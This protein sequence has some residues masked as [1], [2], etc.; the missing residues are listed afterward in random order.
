M[1]ASLLLTGFLAALVVFSGCTTQDTTK[2]HLGMTKEEVIKIMGKPY[3]VGANADTEYLNYLLT[4][5]TIR[6][7]PYNFSENKLNY[8]QS[9]SQYGSTTVNAINAGP[10]NVTRME[11]YIVAL[12]NGKVVSFGNRSQLGIKN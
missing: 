11:S 3:S 8:S 7:H 1:K 4:S 9:H 10:I 6:P 12:K 2:L 5:R